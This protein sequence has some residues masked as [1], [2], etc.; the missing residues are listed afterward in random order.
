MRFFRDLLVCRDLRW[1]RVWLAFG[2]CLIA[3]VFYFSLTPSVL[4]PAEHFDKLFHASTYALMM[5]WFVQL[6]RGRRSHLLLAIAFC[7]MGA[8]IE[9]LQGFHPMRYFDVLDMLANAVGVVVV[10]V[11]AGG[12]FS[13]LLYRIEQRIK[14][15]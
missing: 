3:A 4:L 11:F 8:G 9:I 2:I 12:G 7:T 1:F 10:L 15:G 6:Y 13:T 14:P 5:G